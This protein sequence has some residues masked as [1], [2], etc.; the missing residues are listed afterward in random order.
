MPASRRHHLCGHCGFGRYCHRCDQVKSLDETIGRA[1]QELK[2][3]TSGVVASVQRKLEKAEAA[4]AAHRQNQPKDSWDEE[5]RLGWHAKDVELDSEISELQ[6]D[7]YG[8]KTAAVRTQEGT[9]RRL[10]ARRDHLR[11]VPNSR[12]RKDRHTDRKA[13][14]VSIP[15]QYEQV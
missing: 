4:Q 1:Q 5:K 8:N 11:K 2:Q 15:D 14:V 7:L 9:V 13:G 6:G 10:M 12:S 3:L